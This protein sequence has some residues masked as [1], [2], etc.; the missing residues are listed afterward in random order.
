[1]SWDHNQT[2][3]TLSCSPSGH[4]RAGIT[5]FSVLPS[6][7]NMHLFTQPLF[8]TYYEA[9]VARVV[10]DPPSDHMWPNAVHVPS[11]YFQ[12]RR[13][14][15]SGNFVDSLSGVLGS[16]DHQDLQPVHWDPTQSPA[17]LAFTCRQYRCWAN[18][19]ATGELFLS[20]PQHSLPNF[21]Y[22]EAERQFC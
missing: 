4:L 14:A 7:S 8:G 16:S 15:I 12:G 19:G 21:C 3:R 2:G 20:N 17:I 1:M 6:G 9:H 18:A 22:G 11:Y 10:Q 5:S 13:A